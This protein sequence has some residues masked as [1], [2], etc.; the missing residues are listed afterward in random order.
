MNLEERLE[1][2][3]ALRAGDTPAAIAGRCARPAGTISRDRVA[4][5][6]AWRQPRRRGAPCGGRPAWGGATGPVSGRH[7]RLL[8]ALQF[9]RPGTVNRLAPPIFAGLRGTFGAGVPRGFDCG[10]AGAACPRR[11][12][13]LRVFASLS[14][15]FHLSSRDEPRH[16]APPLPATFGSG[17]RCGYARGARPGVGRAGG[18]GHFRGRLAGGGCQG[19]HHP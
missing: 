6:R 19:R 15:G 17:R 10:V 12:S 9:Q 11:F 13:P 18:R 16:Y 5:W 2:E 14:I 4:Q 3:A 8:G 7:Q 1:L